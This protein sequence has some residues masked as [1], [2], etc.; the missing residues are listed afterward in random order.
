MFKHRN[1]VDKN[2]KGEDRLK[3]QAN[4]TSIGIYF[5]MLVMVVTFALALMR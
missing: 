1:F 3:Q 5:F 2:S 4:T